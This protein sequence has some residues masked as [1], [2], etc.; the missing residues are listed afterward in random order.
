[1]TSD[2]LAVRNTTSYTLQ[3]ELQRQILQVQF[4]GAFRLPQIFPL[5]IIRPLLL[6]LS[7]QNQRTDRRFQ[8]F[9][10]LR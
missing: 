10:V 9:A 5:Q 7:F 4:L 1:M 3:F 6:L 8:R 2:R